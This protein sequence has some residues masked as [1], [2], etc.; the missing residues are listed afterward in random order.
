MGLHNAKPTQSCNS[1]HVF[2]TFLQLPSNKVGHTGDDYGKL[3]MKSGD[4]C[5]N[6]L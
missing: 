1:I 3:H 2:S 6:V 5:E 4:K